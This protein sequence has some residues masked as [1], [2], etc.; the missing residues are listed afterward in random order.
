MHA[1]KLKETTQELHLEGHAP[2]WPWI[3]GTSP[4]GPRSV[5]A[6]DVGPD[7]AG[8]SS[9]ARFRHRIQLLLNTGAFNL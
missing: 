1:K 8:P 4:G 7:E 3:R 6:L 2:S 5:V 9:C